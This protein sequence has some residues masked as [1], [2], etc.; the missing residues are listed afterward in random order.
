MCWDYRIHLGLDTCAINRRL[1]KV[2]KTAILVYSIIVMSHFYKFF[3]LVHQPSFQPPSSLNPGNYIS[4]FVSG[5]ANEIHAGKIWKAQEW[6]LTW[7]LQLV[8][9]CSPVRSSGAPGNVIVDNAFLLLPD[10]CTSA[11]VA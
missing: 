6:L 10:L 4:G 2:F 9:L 8:T 3:V 1:T 7:R 11:A 5:S